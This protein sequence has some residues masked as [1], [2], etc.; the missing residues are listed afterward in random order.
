MRINPTG[1]SLPSDIKRLDSKGPNGQ[2]VSRA[3]ASAANVSTSATS[4]Q[5][6]SIRELSQVLEQAADVRESVVEDVKLKI[7]TGEYLTKEAAL[8]T[9]RSILDL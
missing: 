1:N 9:A 5:L 7:Q 8:N 2:S 4:I 6:D 3:D